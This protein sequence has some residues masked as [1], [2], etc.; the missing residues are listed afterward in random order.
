MHAICKDTWQKC[1]LKL[2]ISLLKLQVEKY[3]GDAGLIS[4][5]LTNE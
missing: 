1:I 5:N 2:Q 4:T 3:H